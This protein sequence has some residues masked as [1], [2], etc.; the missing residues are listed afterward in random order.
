[1]LAFVDSFGQVRVYRYLRSGFCWSIIT[2][3]LV[4]VD[5]YRMGRLTFVQMSPVRSMFSDNYANVS[6]RRHLQLVDNHG[7]V[8]VCR[9]FGSG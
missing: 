6:V 3:R 5:M 9:P 2:L 4:L 8:S 7:Y 1:M